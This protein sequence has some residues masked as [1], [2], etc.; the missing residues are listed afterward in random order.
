ML[1][2]IRARRRNRRADA[3]SGAPAAVRCGLDR[4]D[5]RR[6]SRRP[7]PRP[8]PRPRLP[9]DRSPPRQA[10][11]ISTRPVNRLVASRS[12]IACCSLWLIIQAVLAARGGAGQARCRRCPA[13]SASCGRGRETRFA[14]ATWSPRRSSRRS[15]RFAGDA[16]WTRTICSPARPRCGPSRPRTPV[17]VDGLARRLVAAGEF[18]G[19]EAEELICSAPRTFCRG[20]M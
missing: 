11:S 1:V 12:I 20:P 15:A 2:P 16:R 18:D 4:G 9:P 5:E 7:R 6:L 19:A 3:T 8:R 10:S 17:A 14:A 13:C